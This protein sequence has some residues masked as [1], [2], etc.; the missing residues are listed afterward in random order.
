MMPRNIQ[1]RKIAE[2]HTR[3]YFLGTPPNAWESTLLYIDIDNKTPMKKS[4]ARRFN[5]NEERKLKDSESDQLEEDIAHNQQQSNDTNSV[6]PR[7]NT[8]STDRDKKK[9]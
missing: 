3:C 1:F 9:K 5:C 6:S 8:S 2:D 7:S 4:I